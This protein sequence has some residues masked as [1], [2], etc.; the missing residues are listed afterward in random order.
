MI[1]AVTSANAVHYRRELIEMFRLRHRAFRERLD[2]EVE[3][4]D[5]IERD[6]FDDLDPIYLLYINEAGHVQGSARLLSTTGPYMLRDVFAQVLG[7]EEAP[8][9]PGVW[10]SSRFAA[11]VQHADGQG[12]AALSRITSMLLCGEFELAFVNGFHGIVS[13][14]DVRMERV[15]QRA[16]LYEHGHRIGR[17]VRIGKTRTLAGYFDVSERMV[18]T[19]RSVFGVT[20]S[21]F[22]RRPNFQTKQAA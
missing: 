5:G 7:G 13:V 12:I 18:T 15:L 16:K 2:W 21:V 8:C 9:D 1:H 22:A 10:E 6:R 20:D 14:Y 3:S 17:E 11:E 19:L 4:K